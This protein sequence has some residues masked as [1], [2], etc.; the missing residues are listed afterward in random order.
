MSTA[1]NVAPDLHDRPR[2][3][4]EAA[5]ALRRGCGVAEDGARGKGD[6]RA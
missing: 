1:A 2:A 6:R 3:R 4:G 5:N